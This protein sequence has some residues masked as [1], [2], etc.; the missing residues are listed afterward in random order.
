MRE[1]KLNIKRCVD[2]T[3]VVVSKETIDNIST[4]INTLNLSII[5]LKTKLTDSSLD[6]G[7]KEILLQNVENS[8]IEILKL[9]N[10]DSILEKENN[11]RYSE[12][13]KV[14]ILNRELRRQLGEKVSNE[15][16]REKM[17]NISHNVY[18]WWQEFG[19]G[20]ISETQFTDYG[21]LKLKLSGM[22]FKDTKKKYL[23]NLGFQIEDR[24][25]V[26]NDLTINLLENLLKNKYPNGDINKIELRNSI[27]NLCI[28]YIEFVVSD[29]DDIC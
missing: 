8:S 10:Y 12:I 27:K 9:L 18:D 11:E 23:N 13:Q 4:Q 3:P 20:H 14:N 22:V 1:K 24:S 5:Q 21:C 7:Y 6:E 19:F 2:K 25:I 16:L 15:D 17:K 28:D 26:Y 29:L